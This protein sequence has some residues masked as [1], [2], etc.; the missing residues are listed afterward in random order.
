MKRPYSWTATLI[1]AI[2]T[3]VVS[4]GTAYAGLFSFLAP[5]IEGSPVS[6]QTVTDN[7]LQNLQTLALLQAA[8]NTDP[9]PNKIADEIPIENNNTLSPSVAASNTGTDSDQLN[10]QVTSYS[11]Q[12]GDNLSVIAN[13][14][15]IS[16]DTIKQANHLIGN[17][18]HVGQSLVI[19]PVSGVLYAV[20]A[21]DSIQ[22]IADR[23]K[24]DESDIYAYN[25]LTSSSV[26][27]KGQELIIPH[28][29]P[30]VSDVNSFLARQKMH[31][32]SFEPLLDPVW[33]W[34]SYTDY[35]TCPVPGA[36]L[37][38]GLHG[39]NAVDLAIGLNTPI[40]AAAAG[41]VIV[42]KSNGYYGRSSN[43]GYGNFVMIAHPN[44]A[45]TLYAHM[46]RP[47]V[48]VGESV[49]QGE[50][51]GYIGMTGMT[52]GPHVHF[53][54]RNAANPFVDPALCK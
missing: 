53:E 38:Q 14:F 24:V 46:S 49:A 29:K 42:S 47:A 13:M 3:L 28:G 41:T 1:I 37:S 16:V 50:I 23:Y 17:N 8:V 27:V 6:A 43:G 33:N 48:S 40:R 25:N 39:H 19:L 52:T 15:D 20:K 32:P 22:K 51:I 7:N 34:P 44:G 10:T 11:V 2:T 36:H 31:V 45:E 18:V 4:S 5:L 35:W 12:E 9:N 26:I 30:S 54:I 21:G